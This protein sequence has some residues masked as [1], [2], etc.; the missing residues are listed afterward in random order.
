MLCGNRKTK[1]DITF[2]AT[3]TTR[4]APTHALDLRQVI[5]PTTKPQAARNS[6][7]KIDPIR[8]SAV[9]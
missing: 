4:T 6:P 9:A 8:L 7:K 2:T 3:A 1:A 5:Y